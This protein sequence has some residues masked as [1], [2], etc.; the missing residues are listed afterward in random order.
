M[1]ARQQHKPVV[2]EFYTKWCYGCRLFERKTLPDPQVRK[3]LGRVL[4]ARYDAEHG[5]GEAAAQRY[6]I[7]SYPSI[8]VVDGSGAL[9]QRGSVDAAGVSGFLALLRHAEEATRSREGVQQLVDAHRDDPQVL[10]QAAHWH[11]AH[12]LLP[13]AVVLYEQAAGQAASGAAAAAQARWELDKLRRFLATRERLLADAREQLSRYPGTPSAGKALL[14]AALAGDLPAA[15]VQTL[16]ASYLQALAEPP[17]LPHPPQEESEASRQSVESLTDAIAVALAARVYPPAL[18]A[19]QR[20][21]RARPVLTQAQ[22]LL[23]RAYNDSGDRAAALALLDQ[24]AAQSK[25]PSLRRYY[26][27]LHR[28]LLRQGRLRCWAVD[29]APR[30]LVSYFM[31]LEGGYHPLDGV[32]PVAPLLAPGDAVNQAAASS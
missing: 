6:R 18:A 13:D 5:A 1:T 25:V 20:L 27:G 19:A 10:L 29:S 22:L 9:C 30:R 21:V 16:V 2:L 17:P 8:L 28:G 12:H 24:A 23:A 4:F 3:E 14:I 11:L 26:R 32:E 15:E 31:E 7:S